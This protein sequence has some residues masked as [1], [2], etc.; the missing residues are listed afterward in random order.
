MCGGVLIA[1]LRFTRWYSR[2]SAL[3]CA[4]PCHVV[5]MNDAWRREGR[6]RMAPRMAGATAAQG[7]NILSRPPPSSACLPNRTL[8]FLRTTTTALREQSART[9]P[10]VSVSPPSRGLGM[11]GPKL[12]VY[13]IAAKCQDSVLRGSSPK[14]SKQYVRGIIHFTGAPR[15]HTCVSAPVGRQSE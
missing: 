8:C 2:H 4:P 3:G 14:K 12:E 5:R 6:T 13:Y 11:C 10:R 9:A 1:R 15:P 7:R